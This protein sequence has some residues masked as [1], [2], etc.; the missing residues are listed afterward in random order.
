MTDQRA[1]LTAALAD[2]YRIER[3]LGQGGMAT[4]YLAQD[5]RHDRKVALKVLKP[6][7]AAVIGAERFVVEIKTTAALQHPHILPLFDSGTAD[8][9][10]Y[11]VMPFID[12]ET[13]RSKLDRETQLGIAEAV[14]ITVA[15]ADALDYAHRQGVIHRDIKPENILLHDGRPMVADFGIALALSA[16]AGGRMTETGMSL[17]TPHYMSP[18]Q[19]TAEKEITARSDIYSLGSV[20]YEMLTGNPPHVG[21]SAQQIIM[22]IVTEDAAPVTKLRKSVPPNVAAAVS[23]SLEKLPADRFATAAEFGAALT[24]PGYTSRVTSMTASSHAMARRRN[25]LTVAGW[26]LWGVTLL[27]GLWLLSRAG[28]GPQPVRR[29]AIGM[30]GAEAIANNTIQVLA[31]SPDGGRIGFVGGGVAG[32]RQIWIRDRDQ[33]HARPLAGTDGA[34]GLSWSPDGKQ[35]AFVVSPG[36][37]KVAAVD[38]A[39][40][41][42]VADSLVSV[43]GTSWGPDGVIYSAGGFRSAGEGIVGVPA[44]GGIPTARTI[45]DSARHEFAHLS[46]AVLPNNRGLVFSIWYGPTRPNETEIAVLEFKTGAYRILQRGLRARYLPTGHLLIARAD[47]SLVAVPFDQDKLAITGTPVPVVTGVATQAGYV[48]DYD[49]SGAGTLMYL[50]G[51]PGNVKEMVQPVWVTR[52]GVASPVDSGWTFNRPYN[53]GMSLSPD[54]TRLAVAIAGEP[55]SDI[56]IKQLD[57][58]PLSRLTFEEFLKYRPV[59]SPDGRTVTYIADPGNNNAGLFR[60]RADGSGDVERLLASD[61]ALAEALW[62]RDGQWLVVRTTLPSRDIQAFR[63]GVDTTLTP[64]VATPR[65]DERAPT[66]SP[67]GRWVAYQSDETG[68]SEIYVRPFPKA[69]EGRWQISTAGGEE[70]LWSRGGG[71]IFF[72]AASGEMMT[73]PVTTSPAFSAGTPAPLFQAQSYARSL[74]YRAYDVSPDDRRFVMLRPAADSVRTPGRQLVVVDNW[75]EE[76]RAKLRNK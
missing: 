57:H 26:A 56:W 21:A 12:G 41:T 64:I 42:V 74:S 15:V 70:P 20:L 14:K 54:G 59:W 68:K 67:D 36:V 72:R 25:G 18:E 24:D 44:S 34:Q 31:L 43:G 32:S 6:E 71:D 48:V 76:L 52:Q 19:A 3:E 33:L 55:T 27:S 39:A 60:K 28:S 65:F 63:P 13:L 11:Y 45:L 8:G 38:G 16:A 35:V 23:R 9:F 5:L 50:A 69:G 10:L 58:G 75:F 51:E 66:L 73:V 49:V 37:L 46:P 4:V 53:G 2:R 30:T 47:G 7:L 22:R 61:K 29:Y 62:S 40:P 17:G 1:S